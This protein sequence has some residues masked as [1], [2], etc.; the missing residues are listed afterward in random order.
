MWYWLL[1][2]A[3]QADVLQ[4][5]VVALGSL[6]GHPSMMAQLQ[7]VPSSA[8]PPEPQGQEDAAM[9]QLEALHALLLILPLPQVRGARWIRLATAISPCLLSTCRLSLMSPLIN[10]QIREA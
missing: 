3:D 9:L 5:T 7:E 10:F 1:G 2:T 4:H 8:M 6:I